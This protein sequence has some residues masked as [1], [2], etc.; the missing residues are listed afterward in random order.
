MEGVGQWTD[1]DESPIF[2]PARLEDV[3]VLMD[4]SMRLGKEAE[5]VDL[6]P[7]LLQE[8]LRAVLA[9]SSKGKVFVA[10]WG[11]Q[12]VGMM[13]L[14]YEWSD[15]KNAY[16]WWIRCAYVIRNCRRKGIFKGLYNM[17]KREAIQEGACGTRLYVYKP[18]IEAI[19][20]YKHFGMTSHYDMYE[21]LHCEY[22]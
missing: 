13:K 19:E 12:V 5:N 1:L 21:D 17:V 11:G 6:D 7:E 8:G 9:D 4:M 3:P 15:W 10:E 2:R 14:F 18:N 16:L 20:F 22:A